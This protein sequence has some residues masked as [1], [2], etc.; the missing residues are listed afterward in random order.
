MQR[1]QWL[2][3]LVGGVLGLFVGGC[4]SPAPAVADCPEAAGAAVAAR[5]PDEGEHRV[6]GPL[7]VAVTVDDLP[8]HGPLPP[9]V[10]RADVHERLL[11]AFEEHDVP[12]VYG[13]VNAT[14]VERDPT[15][16]P[17]LRAWTEAGHP[18]G[19]HTY[20]HADLASVGTAAYLEDI[21]RNEPFLRRLSPSAPKMFRY[22]YL[23]EGVDAESMTSI[24][25]HLSEAGYQ[26]A[27]VT[28]DFYDWA[29]NAPYA[30]C[31]EQG[32]TEAVEALER[33]FLAHA[34]HVLEWSDAAAIQMH[35]R[36]I[37]HVLLLHAGAFDASMVERLLLAYESR[38]VHW[39]P[40]EE[41]LDDPA[42]VRPPVRDGR[43]QGTLLELVIEAP[44]LEHPPWPLHPAP[45]LEALCQPSPP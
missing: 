38:G 39:I 41:A 42:Y 34:V 22:P 3:T 28:I 7:R 14:H 21:A 24:A 4:R 1:A 44:D 17:V 16:E 35:G 15:L 33:M 45:L 31:L 9:G 36:R 27:E 18:L 37:P 43:M 8:R 23:L 12:R 6:L 29:F 5:G 26:I 11:A 10:T 13:F 30:R 2:G 40:L 25:T 20:S 32:R 19:N